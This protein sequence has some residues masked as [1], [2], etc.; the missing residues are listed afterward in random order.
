MSFMKRVNSGRRNFRPFTFC[1]VFLLSILAAFLFASTLMQA[2]QALAQEQNGQIEQSQQAG[3]SGQAQ[4]SQTGSEPIENVSELDPGDHTLFYAFLEE[5]PR[6]LGGPLIDQ[7]RDKPVFKDLIRPQSRQERKFRPLL[8][9]RLWCDSDHPFFSSALFMMLVLFVSWYLLPG[10]L[11]DGVQ[12]LRKKFWPS[13]GTGLMMAFVCMLLT[14]AAFLSQLGWPLGIMLAGLAQSAMLL[15]LSVSVL[16]LG[17][18]VSLVLKFNNLPFL[19]SDASRKRCLDIVIGALVAALILQI[20]ALGIFPRCGTRLMA[21]FAL[22]G[23]GS[24]F[25]AFQ[26]KRRQ[27]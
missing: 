8:Q 13:F 2:P 4:Q 22:L 9:W 14:R 18:A 20:P 15:G 5:E 16:N 27:S 7:F 1:L 10:F 21:L 19:Q 23:V 25:R 6:A 11:Q 17:H 3:Q 26:E 24:L 12:E